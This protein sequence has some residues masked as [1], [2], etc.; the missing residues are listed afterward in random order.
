MNKR[1]KF[2]KNLSEFNIQ[3]KPTVE[4]VEF[5]DV[6]T[7]QKFINDVKSL[8]GGTDLLADL[9]KFKTTHDKAAKEYDTIEKELKKLNTAQDKLQTTFSKAEDNFNKTK[10]TLNQLERRGDTLYGQLE[11]A[12]NLLEQSAKRLGVSTPPIVKE[13]NKLLRSLGK[14]LDKWVRAMKKDLK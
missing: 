13:A 14:D 4:K 8:G 3:E 6:K 9:D 5:K 11:N 10:S 12:S 7:V 2:Y 1:E